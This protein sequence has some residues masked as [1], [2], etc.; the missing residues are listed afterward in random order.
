M[1]K[2]KSCILTPEAPNGEPSRL[3]ER[4]LEKTSSRPLANYLYAAYV[5][6]DVADKMDSA[7]VQRNNQQQHDAEKY[8]K[9]IDFD[10]YVAESAN[11]NL[12]ELKLGAIDSNGVRVSFPNAEDALTKA[13]NFN[14]SHNALK[15]IVVQVGDNYNII[16]AEKDSRTHTYGNFVKDKLQVWDIYKQAFNGIGV[17]I[18]S[19]PQE[20][21]GTFNA[22]NST[23]A[24]QLK[25]LKTVDMGDMYKRD[26]MILFSLSPNSP[27][28]QRVVNAFGSIEK[29]AEAIDDFNAGSRTLTDGQKTLLKRAILDAKNYQGLDID[30]LINQV[31][32]ASTNLKTLSP[33]ENIK[34]TLV[35]LNKK[36]KI[37][38]NEVH[39]ASRKIR[40]LSEA[41]A[42]AV[43]TL[44]RKIRE[45]EKQKGSNAE[46]KQLET[47]LNRLMKELASKNYYLGINGFLGEASKYI[48]EID[49]M[50]TNIPQTGTEMEKAFGT[51]KILHGINTIYT[52]YYNIISALA[53]KG[54]AIDESLG[55]DAIDNIRD[56]ATKLKEYLDAKKGMLDSLTETTMTNLLLSTIGQGTSDKNALINAVKLA[57]ADST[58]YTYFYS[59]GEAKNPIIASAGL[60]VRN[61]Q[62]SRDKKLNDIAYRIRTATNKLYSAGH[63]SKFMYEDDGHIVSDINWELFE[64]TKDKKAKAL[65][66]SG[67]RGFDLKQALDSWE[68]SVTEDRVVDNTNGRTERVPNAAFR[69]A[70][71]FQQ[72]WSQA[73]KDYYETMMQIKGEIGSLLPSYAQKQY[74]SPQIRRNFTDTI[75]A[76]EVG[77]A[78]KNKL[79][80][81]YKVR[82]DDENF[83]SN[84]I[85]DGE[86]YEITQGGYDNTPLRQI[87]IFYVNKLKE[88][89]ELMKDFS[90]GIQALAST[91]INYEA[92]NNIFDV[93]D[94]MNTFVS[95]QD[96]K[97]KQSKA[98]I[99]QNQEVRVYKTLWKHA[100]S[101]NTAALMEGF[102]EKHFYGQHYAPDTNKTLAK[103][104]SSLIQYT[105]F[106]GLSTNFKGMVANRL[107]G[108]FQMFIEAG[109]GEFYNFTDFTWAHFKIYG[110]A[111]AGGD[112]ME[113][114]TNNMSHKA[115]LMREEFDPLG[116]NFSDKSHQRYYRSAFRQLISHD[117][118]FIGYSAGE[119]LI[120]YINMYAVLHHTKVLLNGKKTNLYDA[121][122]VSKKVDGNAKLQLKAGVTDL[123]G[124]AITEEFIHKIR[125]RIRKVNHD[126]HGAMNEE[127]KG[128]IHQYLW[129]RLIM[130]FR[131]WM[132]G[133]YERRFRT[134]H[135]DA[136]TEDEREGYWYSLYKGLLNEDTK[137]VWGKGHHLTA[138]GLIA[139][140]FLTFMLRASTHWE[141]LD[142]MQKYNIKR[143]K[144]EML[145]FFLLLGASFALGDPDKH[146][147]EFWRRFF[148]YQVKRALVDTEAGMP[149]LTILANA[150]TMLNSPMAGIQTMNGFL[151]VFYG[152][153]NGDLFTKIKSGDHKGENKYFRNVQKYVLP[154]FK[155]IEQMQKLSTDENVFKVF[156]ATPSNH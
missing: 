150:T 151:Y 20:V 142:E 27:H 48:V 99:V 69:K 154:V 72:N 2:Y 7:G 137:D 91:A 90:A 29:A 109:A 130:N 22:M 79:Q 97:A 16:V 83:A 23:L 41:T 124:N 87:P 71:D 96:L 84:G 119:Y 143:V 155:D 156:D 38:I 100:V 43:V 75:L 86:N 141:H 17:D 135:Y 123:D 54:L 104:V 66:A 11:L 13:D 132:V 93:V 116:E 129:G 30:A 59:M 61:A 70:I 153:Y 89:G 108:E 6:S 39:R 113:L 5:T 78:V 64:N 51:A 85:I 33:E 74:L 65:Y 82:E 67:L 122:E 9:F 14:N 3:Y 112:I 1:G 133:F 126:T 63:N 115:T 25:N 37:N 152:L 46:G 57:V 77:K 148:I 107:M 144:T 24:Q 117:C 101:S 121:Y 36:Y 139:K 145:T 56:S 55:Q 28:V 44:Q 147:K 140:D 146:K 26:A 111:G 106:K 12:E 80:N 31:K 131:Q 60:I 73:Q 103:A 8:L 21:Q 40:T 42:D 102:M 47:V 81:I 127:D 94:F 114:C 120:H 58:K 19:M 134:R 125:K 128:L 95:T 49:N 136:N 35:T 32:A 110:N 4:L 10:A 92:M 68:E 98:E 18:T 118:S 76:G 52:Q 34:N 15:A 53:N 149:G 62:D 50:L 88:G 45:L 105:S 138:M